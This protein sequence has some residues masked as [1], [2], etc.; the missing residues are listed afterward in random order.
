[1]R[2]SAPIQTGPGAKPA[3]YTMGTRSFPGVKLPGH[4]VDHPPHLVPRQKKKG[5]AI[6]LL[7]LWAFVACSR[8]NLT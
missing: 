7:P 6:P 1:V 4:G 2:F 8:V 5:R 3:S